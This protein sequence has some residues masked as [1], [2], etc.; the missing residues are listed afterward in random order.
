MYH[1][2]ATTLELD[3]TPQLAERFTPPIVSAP[4]GIGYLKRCLRVGIVLGAIGLSIFVGYKFYVLVG[5][6]VKEAGSQ[7]LWFNIVGGH[8]GSGSLSR[9]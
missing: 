8:V 9:H 7:L 6:V 1:A 4:N 5:G 2:D 3:T